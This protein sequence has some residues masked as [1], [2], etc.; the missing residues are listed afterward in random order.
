[1]KILVTDGVCDLAI[2]VFKNAGLHVDV[3]PTMPEEELAK[4][5]PDYDGFVVRSATKV[6][7]KIM[8]NAKK[9][10]VIGRAGVGV[11]NIDV[12]VATE[13]KIAVMNTPNGNVNAAA[14][15][16]L[17]MMLGLAR[18]IHHA[19]AHME[20]GGWERKKY[21][22]FE[23]RGKTLGIV[24][25][26]KIGRRVSE[27][28]HSLGMNIVAYDPIIKESG[29]GVAMVPFDDLLE[30][31]DLITIHV[32]L[33]EHTKYMF[34]EPQ[35][36]K[37]K[38]NAR[39]INVARGGLINENAL[40]NAIECGKIAGAAIDV[41]ENEPTGNLKLAAMDAV[42]STPHLGASTKEAQENVAIDVAEQMVA[43]FKEGKKI[44][45]VNKV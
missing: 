15:H 23:L 32:P 20:A 4:I 45:L 24:G 12:P 6:T 22:G 44:N 40:C 1:M 16:T 25:F 29:N 42:L 19:H 33:N 41:W 34:D 36:S 5:I 43:F 9:L 17:A 38:K 11:D 26:G 28:A 7:K 27:F 39:I 3:K 8:D 10:K 2:G 14:E 21:T 18:H 37:M 31:S 13:K 30:K 35:F